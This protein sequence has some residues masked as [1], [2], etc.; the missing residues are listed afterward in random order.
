[1]KRYLVP[2]ALLLLA[3]CSQVAP[4]PNSHT[5][6]GP[7]NFGTP[8]FD[9]AYGLARHSSGVY[10]VWYT[11]GN[12]HGTPKGGN[13]AFVRKYDRSGT[14]LWG[15]RFGTAASDYALGAASD[16]GNNVYVVGKQKV[17]LSPLSGAGTSS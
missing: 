16:S 3:S 13:D 10:A 4:T 7:S 8:E 15:R 12:L 14:I 9:A 2:F 5:D 1:M 17:V 11:E 6:L